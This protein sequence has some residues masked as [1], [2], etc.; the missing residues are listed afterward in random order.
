MVRDSACRAVRRDGQRC[1]STVVLPSGYCAMHDPERQGEVAAARTRG[2]KQ[3]ATTARLDRLVPTTL[4]PVLA[5]LLEALDE[6]RG[7]GDTPPRLSPPQ[8]N[9]MASLAGAIVKVYQAGTLEERLQAL[10][11][12][13]ADGRSGT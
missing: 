8:A 3:K 2:G 5:T 12:A 1:R 4:K 7:E 13:H 6:V 9:A 11:Q 10:E